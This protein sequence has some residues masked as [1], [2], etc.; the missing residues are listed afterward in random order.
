MALGGAFLAAALVARLGRRVGLPTIPFFMAAGVLIGPYTPGIVLVANPD[1]LA[2]FATV[3]L[4]L[5]L[6]HLGLE[7]SVRDLAAGGPR[8]LGAGAIDFLLNV[9]GGIAWASPSGGARARRSWWAGWWG[10][11]RP[12]SSPSRWSSCAGRPTQRPG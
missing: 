3:G 12:P 4:V 2:V 1:D 5:V 7:F 8:L 11:R 10:S 9:G 6:F